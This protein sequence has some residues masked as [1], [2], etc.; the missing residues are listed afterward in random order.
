MTVG[1]QVTIFATD[2]SLVGVADPIDDWQ[3]ID[4]TPQLMIAASGKLVAPATDN[5]L[6][7]IQP[8]NR[9]FVVYRGQTFMAGPIEKCGPYERTIGG[10]VGTITAYFTDDLAKIVAQLT[11]PDPGLA[12]NA[13]VV[14]YYTSTD[15]AEEQLYTLVDLNVGAG[16]LAARQIP[17]LEVDAAAS[18]GG[19]FQLKTRFEPMGDCMRRIARGGGLAFRTHQESGPNRIVFTVYE[20]ADLT[21]ALVFSF[22]NGNLQAITIDPEAPTVTSAIVGGDGAGAARPVVVRTDTA[23]EALWWRMER[24]VNQPD[25]SNTT[26]LNQAGDDELAQ[27]A[28]QAGVSAVAVDIDGYRYGTDYQIGDLVGLVGKPGELLAVQVRGVRLS[29]TPTEGVVAAPLLGNPGEDNDKQ[30][31]RQIHDLQRRLGRTERG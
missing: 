20:P 14:A 3:E 7:A 25:T 22:D 2:A 9:L 10:G 19:S 26:E 24:F 1:S 31:L 15:P 16:A 21:T 4:C 13:Q 12:A 17:G 23:A 5:N 8:G 30:W 27:G 18:I 28:E 29:G 11:Y 6:Q